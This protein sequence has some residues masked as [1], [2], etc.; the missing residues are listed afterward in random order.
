MSLKKLNSI[1]RTALRRAPARPSFDLAPLQGALLFLVPFQL[2]L[3]HLA[4]GAAGANGALP[5]VHLELVQAQRRH[6]VL[7]WVM[8]AALDLPA[9]ELL[10]QVLEPARLGPWPCVSRYGG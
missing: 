7:C 3:T 2:P 1:A 4:V 8:D 6:R 5:L 10:G 9:E